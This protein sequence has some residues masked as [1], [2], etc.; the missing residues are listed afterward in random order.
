MQA[1]MNIQVMNAYNVKRIVTTCPHS[2]NT[3]K[4]EYKGLGGKY[5]VL[6]HTEYINELVTN[7]RFKIKVV[8]LV[9]KLHITTR[10][11]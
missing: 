3:L 7:N 9:K 2:Y 11:I 6:H 4:N 10:V 5:D 8:L 1:M